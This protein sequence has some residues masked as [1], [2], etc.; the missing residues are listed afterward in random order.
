MEIRART[1]T[2]IYQYY[3]QHGYNTVVMGRQLP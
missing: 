3:K 1:V 2:E